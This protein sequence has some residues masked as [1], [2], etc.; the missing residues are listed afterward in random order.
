MDTPSYQ[1]NDRIRGFARD[2][3][4]TMTGPEKAA[5]ELFRRMGVRVATQVP[6]HHYILDFVDLDQYRIFEIDGLEHRKEGKRKDRDGVRD[7]FFRS[8][9][10]GVVRISNQMV[11]RNPEG[12]AKKASSPGR[13]K[14][15]LAT[16]DPELVSV[17]GDQLL[18]GG[19]P[20]GVWRL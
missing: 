2:L 13:G 17:I 7:H 16:L 20:R 19:W 3:Q 18:R 12:F 8:H 15:R 6:V 14:K 4:G 1:P 5:L 11:L 9:G 10:I